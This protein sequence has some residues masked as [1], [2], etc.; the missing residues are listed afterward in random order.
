MYC[1]ENNG[2]F[3]FDFDSAKTKKTLELVAEKL[4]GEVR[5]VLKL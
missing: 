3:I 4:I 1:D 2:V 5:R